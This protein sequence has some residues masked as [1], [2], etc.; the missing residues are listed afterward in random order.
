MFK[1]PI[2]MLS[3]LFLFTQAGGVLAQ[4]GGNAAW[5]AG[6]RAADQA[7]WAAYNRADAD[8]MNAWL[9]PD[10]EFYHDRGGKLIG[11]KALSAANDVMKTN[12]VKLRREAV[13]GTLRFFPMRE[14]K[15]VYG[16]V[17]TGEHNFY[18]REPGR[19]EAFVGRAHF[20]HLMR[21]SGKEWRVA[22][23]YS[24]EHVDAPARK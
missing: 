11:K 15:T 9:A 7:Y 23:I 13:P 6:P 2:V 1:I 19:K 22:R 18:A 14:G 8:A 17:V 10:V 21:L 16:A 12:P 3:S 24:Y 20:S 4:Q 5:E